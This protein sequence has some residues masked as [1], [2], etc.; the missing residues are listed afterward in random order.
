MAIN[1]CKICDNSFYVKPSH[2]RNGWGLFCSRYCK[3]LGTRERVNV[4]CFICNKIIYKTKSQIKRS[5][6]GKFFCGK[7]CQA[8][9]RNVEYGGNKHKGWKGGQSTY[10]KLM[11][12]NERGVRCVLCDKK[13]IRILAVHHLDEDHANLDINN[14]V[15]LCHNCH[16]L[17]HHDKLEKQRLLSV[18]KP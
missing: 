9:W 12:K 4:N 6:S 13:D 16:F 3:H 5:K 18:L 8:K 17:I 7:S 10:R 1:K 2:I 11:L 14:L 15:W